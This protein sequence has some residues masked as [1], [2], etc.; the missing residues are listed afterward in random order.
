MARFGEQLRR[1]RESKDLSIK[2]YADLIPLSISY[3]SEIERG[4]KPSPGMKMMERIAE[5]LDVKPDYFDEYKA[6]KARE[7]VLQDPRLDLLFRLIIRLSRKERDEVLNFVRSLADR[8]KDDSAEIQLRH[9]DTLMESIERSFR[10]VGFDDLK[11]TDFRDLLARILSRGNHLVRGRQGTGKSTL[12]RKAHLECL[13]RGDISFYLDGEV[14]KNL[15]FPE[16]LIRLLEE[17]FSSLGDII[18]DNLERSEG[19]LFGQLMGTARRKKDRENLKK[20]GDAVNGKVVLLEQL[21]RQHAGK[22][23]SDRGRE[24]LREAK[25]ECLEKEALTMGLIFDGICRVGGD[26]AAF[27]HIDDFQYLPAREQA[28]SLDFFHRLSKGKRVFL[29]VSVGSGETAGIVPGDFETVSLDYP[30]E[31][32]RETC[33]FMEALLVLHRESSEPGVGSMQSFFKGDRALPAIVIASGGVARDFLK[34]FRRALRAARARHGRGVRIGLE[35]VRA[36][37][38]EFLAEDRY[39]LLRELRNVSPAR[40]LLLRIR[41]F[42]REKGSCFFK[43]REKAPGSVEGFSELVCTRLLHPVTVLPGKEDGRVY[44]LDAAICLEEGIPVPFEEEDPFR[45][46]HAVLFEGVAH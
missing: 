9:V 2:D 14:H 35:D 18:R 38:L 3:L 41:N 7:A 1:L 5:V 33:R 21:V 31:D 12:L 45:E 37:A 40:D 11:Y 42:C 19:G 34:I 39:V 6:E 44:M 46:S 36:A 28:A 43:V 32:F 20:I 22:E 26:R 25:I 10:I 13:Q 24:S 30:L 4:L 8:S 23:G 29:T 17:L 15:S 27:I 16:N